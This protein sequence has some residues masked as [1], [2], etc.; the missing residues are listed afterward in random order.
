MNDL[1]IG[2]IGG[3]GPEATSEFYMKL[4]KATRA[5]KDQEH[6]HVFIDS[7]AKIPDRTKAIL[8]NGKSPVSEITKTAKNLELLGVDVACMPCMTAHYFIEDIQKEVSYTI[9]NVFEEV[10]KYIYNNFPSHLKVG[11]LATTGTIETGL[12]DKYLGDVNVIYPNHISQKRKVM[13]AIYGENGLKSGQTEGE[14]V[15][16]LIEASN[17]L[18]ESGA[19]II[20]CGCS[21]IGMV[22]KEDMIEKPLIDPM[23]TLVNATIG[24]SEEVRIK[25]VK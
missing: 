17:E 3:M 22:L 16:L 1:K 15:E 8:E 18:I 9:M 21:E 24:H 6:Y 19:N 12:F 11:V 5:K 14:P 10:K 23:D 4:I 25:N 13:E 2:V 7:N 20:I